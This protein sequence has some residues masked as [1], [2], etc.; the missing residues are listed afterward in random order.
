M[1]KKG[2][3]PPK[4]RSA[5]KQA[6][7]EQILPRLQAGENAQRLAEEFGIPAAT[8]RYWKFRHADKNIVQ[9]AKTANNKRSNASNDVGNAEDSGELIETELVSDLSELAAEESPQV[10]QSE[11]LKTAIQKQAGNA[12]RFLGQ[13]KKLVLSTLLEIASLNR[14]A[15]RQYKAILKRDDIPAKEKLQISKRIKE[16][17][18]ATQDLYCLPLGAQKVAAFEGAKAAAGAQH[19][20]I[21]SHGGSAGCLVKGRK[22]QESSGPE[23]LPAPA[24]VIEI[25]PKPVDVN[26]VSR[27]GEMSEA[28]LALMRGLDDF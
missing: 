8:I 19:L 15:I 26:R 2:E 9:T 20:H 11:Q 17:I 25:K 24:E 3:T 14:E 18:E 7:F 12:I 1:L 10:I 5:E 13:S 4:V 22:R 6:A 28:Q 16:L 23:A 21:H 27:A